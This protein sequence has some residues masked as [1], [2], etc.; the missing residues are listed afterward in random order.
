MKPVNELTLH[1]GESVIRGMSR[2]CAAHGGINLAQGFP[3]WDTP[4]EVKEAAVKAIR[5]GYN[6]YAV[7]WAP[8]TCARPSPSGP[9]ATT[10]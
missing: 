4:E 5:E 7:T 3:D 2:I 8:P 1:F 6:Q 9:S 10:T